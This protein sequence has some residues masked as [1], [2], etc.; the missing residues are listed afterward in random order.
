M[1]TFRKGLR[2]GALFAVIYA[3]ISIAALF[4]SPGLMLIPA[5]LAIPLMLVLGWRCSAAEGRYGWSKALL[6][7]LAPAL[8]VCLTGLLFNL[9]GY[10]CVVNKAYPYGLNMRTEDTLG[11]AFLA[12]M[13]L[14]PVPLAAALGG[15]LRNL[16]FTLTSAEP[17]P[18][19]EEKA[20]ED[21]GEKTAGGS[22][23]PLLAFLP[24]FTLLGAAFVI[25]GGLLHKI[26]L[27]WWAGPGFIFMVLFLL[28]TG[29]S[30]FAFYKFQEFRQRRSAEEVWGMSTLLMA[31]IFYFA[32]LL[33]AAELWHF[34]PRNDWETRLV[35]ER[36]ACADE[37][38]KV[39]TVWNVSDS[40]EPG[41]GYINFKA[42]M[43]A[44]K[45][46]VVSAG[47]WI[48]FGENQAALH[49]IPEMMKTALQPGVTVQAEIHVVVNPV[50][51]GIPPLSEDGPYLIPE[52]S[53]YVGD[54]SVPII[55]N[56]RT[57]AYK[58]SD[59]K[60]LLWSSSDKMSFP[61][62]AAKAPEK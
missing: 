10:I 28:S 55:K 22:L 5:A 12:G 44:T 15:L 21:G 17:A 53:A 36:Q 49:F 1:T 27:G 40:Q 60:A 41:S 58:A 9:L 11:M 23:L 8:P 30:M 19:A 3:G 54:C 42:E 47:P 59:F 56:Y 34:P 46:L 62:S 26:V 32:G 57:G 29:G 35:A 16:Y 33:S 6:T 4:I 45:P 18:A 48:N 25:T 61:P 14:V 7:G 52:L 31:G 50:Y 51:T 24:L 43:M 20:A 13:L 37:A 39:L 38:L 2:T